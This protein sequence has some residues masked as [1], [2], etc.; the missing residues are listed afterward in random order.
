METLTASPLYY[1]KSPAHG[2]FLKS[3]GQSVLIQ[4]LD[5]W[6]TEALEQ[7]MKSALFQERYP[8]LPS[9][10]FFI[11]N[12]QE[13]MFLV[14]NLMS[15][16]DHSGRAFPMMLGHLIEI[17]Q[18]QINLLFAPF[19]YKTALINLALMN[20]KLYKTVDSMRLFECL[21]QI[22]TAVD[23]PTHIDCK[24]LFD[25]HTMY[26]FAKLMNISAYEL[27][28]SMI[29]LGLLLQPVLQ[30]GVKQLNKVLT[31]P[32]N[33]KYRSEIAAFWVNLISSFL[34]A[35]NVEIL[36]GILHCK[37]PMLIFGFQGAEISTLRD[38][39]L[40]D[41]DDRHWVSLENAEWVDAYL[42]QNDSLALFEQSLCERQ[43]S[44]NHGMRLFRQFFI[45]ETG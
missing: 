4:V 11:A 24:T 27:A 6:I 21:E 15:S 9:L 32:L 36:F 12:P 28:Q 38:I 22:K 42:K 41:F 40:Q 8:Q 19:R 14:A 23:V 33:E 44:L 16:Q 25:H 34:A 20:K 43:L 5:Q 18:P 13:P 2:D 31:I 10:D 17:S 39:F 45:E 29:G 1:G 3:K 30:K 37:Q 26:S 7:A 35:H